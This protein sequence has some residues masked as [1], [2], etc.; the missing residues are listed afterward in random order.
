MYP[1][2]RLAWQLYKTRNQP[3]LGLLET[4]VSHHICLPW[5]I[6]VFAELNNGRTLTL[7]DMGRIPMGVRAGLMA[8]LK[9]NGWGLT[10]AG[11]SVR[12]RQRVRVFEKIEIR[13]RPVWWDHRFIYIEQSMWKADGRCANHIL[14]RAAITDKKGIVHPT[15]VAIA[16]NVPPEPP[17]APAWVM[18]W[19]AAEDARPWPPD[20]DAGVGPLKDAV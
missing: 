2:I 8:A 14:Y 4:H 5:D 18:A 20:R 1:F 7:Y 15:E 6:D 19:I 13:S 11:A 3:P 10:M 17:A 16:M 12:Y 9:R